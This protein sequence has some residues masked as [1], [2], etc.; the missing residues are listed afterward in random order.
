MI[1]FVINAYPE[2]ALKYDARYTMFPATLAKDVLDSD[3]SQYS[4]YWNISDK[5]K[6]NIVACSMSHKRCLKYIVDNK[7]DECIII[8]DDAVIDFSRVDEIK[9]YK[10]FTYIGGDIRPP[11]LKDDN[12]D[13]RDK[14]RKMIIPDGLNKI[15]TDKFV[16]LGAFGY[17]IPRYQVSER[18]LSFIPV[19]NLEKAIDVEFKKLQKTKVIRDFHYPPLVTLNLEEA[20]T[21]FS[22]SQMTLTTFNEY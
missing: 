14:K 9:E 17:Y 2:R 12:K 21:G 16:I 15:D 18:L 20:K 10:D 8:E 7:L 3:K 1:I 22:A 4:F 5:L 19:N 11:L 13:F 6:S